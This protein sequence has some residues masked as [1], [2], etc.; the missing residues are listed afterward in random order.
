MAFKRHFKQECLKC[1]ALLAPISASSLSC[2]LTNWRD[3]NQLGH[4]LNFMRANP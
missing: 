4:T 3:C 2:I 1:C